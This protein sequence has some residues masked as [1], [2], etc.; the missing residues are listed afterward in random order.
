MK[1]EHIAIW[2]DRLEV[3]K[4]YYSLYF[5]GIAGAMYHN[6]S[7]QFS[8]YFITFGTGARLEL[9]TAPG[10]P[11]N[12]ND[13]VSLQHLGMIHM[14]FEVESKKEV[15]DMA[16]KFRSDGL[17]ILD[18]PRVTGDGYYEFTTCDPDGNR[19]EV[20]TKNY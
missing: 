4:D 5:G 8:S 9:M 2:T 18:G 1:I 19:V 11:V 3:L 15:D 7:R 12:Q 20:T 14:A 10:I 13:P 17:R 6:A 16:A